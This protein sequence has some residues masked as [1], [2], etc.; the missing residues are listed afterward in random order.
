MLTF[1]LISLG[2]AFLVAIAVPILF[3][4]W[5]G[6]EDSEAES[7]AGDRYVHVPGSTIWRALQSWLAAKPRRIQHDGKT[8]LDG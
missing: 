5:L 3:L 6:N 8:D 4:R 2:M 7:P 1:F